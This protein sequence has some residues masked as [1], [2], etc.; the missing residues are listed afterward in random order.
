[1]MVFLFILSK[2]ADNYL[3]LPGKSKCYFE[4]LNILRNVPV[5]NLLFTP[6]RVNFWDYESAFISGNMNGKKVASL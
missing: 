4:H 6:K 2:L 3:Q 5:L 1:M